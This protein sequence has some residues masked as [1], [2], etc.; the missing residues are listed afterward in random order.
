M[1]LLVLSPLLF[2]LYT[3]DCTSN[4]LS[5][6]LLNFADDT[7]VIGLIQDGDETAYGQE[8]KQLVQWCSQ[9]HLELNHKKTVE[10]TEDF[11]RC[12][13]PHTIQNDIVSTVDSFRFL[14]TTIS[15]DLK[16]CPHIYSVQKKAQQ[17][18]YFLRQLRKFNLPKELLTTFY[19]A[20]IQSVRFGSATKRDRARL[21]RT[22]RAA[23]KILAADLPIIIKPQHVEDRRIANITLKLT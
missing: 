22:I 6:K 13:P 2:S 18:L 14:G 11:Q 8:V 4:N 3:N 17:R 9:H 23:E 21:Q 16:W 20:I 10:M 5:V 12:P 1:L 15:Q 7:T 19:S